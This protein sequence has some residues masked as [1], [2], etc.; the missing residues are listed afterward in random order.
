[1]QNK[2]LPVIK[3]SDELRLALLDLTRSEKR[4]Q[5]FLMMSIRARCQFEGIDFDDFILRH[6]RDKK[7]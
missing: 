7:E 2:Q 3:I 6:F 5:E 4:K 1:M